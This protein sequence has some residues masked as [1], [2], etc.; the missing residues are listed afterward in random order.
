MNN[1]VSNQS[2]KIENPLHYLVII[3]GKMNRGIGNKE[4]TISKEEGLC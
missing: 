2:P 3:Q 4:L 1:A